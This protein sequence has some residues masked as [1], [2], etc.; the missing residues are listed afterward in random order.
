MKLRI[1]EGLKIT[2]KKIYETDFGT[3]IVV[4]K[5]G[6]QRTYNSIIH[7]TEWESVIRRKGYF[8][9]FQQAVIFSLCYDSRDNE[10][11]IDA[12]HGKAIERNAWIDS[13]DAENY[14]QAIKMVNDEVINCFR[15]YCEDKMI[16]SKIVYDNSIQ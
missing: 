11:Y 9:E 1:Y 4:T 2:D 13:I 3:F 10:F 16:Y 15:D 6:N 12:E 8:K 7:K 14:K 5:E